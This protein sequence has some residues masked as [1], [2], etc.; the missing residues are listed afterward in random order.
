MNFRQSNFSKN[1][2]PIA[3][4]VILFMALGNIGKIVSVITSVVGLLTP[5]ILGG[6][7]AF[8][9]NMPLIFFEKQVAKYT[10]KSFRTLG[11]IF[12]LLVVAS[13]I[14]IV[15]LLIAP[16]ITASFVSIA[17]SVPEFFTELQDMITKIAVSTPFLKE[18]LSGISIDWQK[19]D[20][21]AVWNT[22]QTFFSGTSDII[23]STVSVA[24]SV[25]SGI[26][27][28]F[29]ALFFSIYVLAQKENLCRQAKKL[30]YAVIPV[31]Y[32]DK[33]VYICSL[34]SKTFKNFITGQ[35]TEAVI[36]G[37]MFFI[38]MSILGL[39]YALLI[40]VLIGVTS[41]VPIFGATVG[42]IVGTFFILIENP[43]QAVYFLIVFLIVQQ[44]EGNVIYPRVV[45]GSVGLPSI[46]VLVAVT[47]GGTSMGLLGMIIFIPLFSIIY[48]LL[49]SFAN[50]RLKKNKIP[51]HK[52]DNT[53]EIE[54]V[55]ELDK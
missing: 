23:G 45:G 37:T 9:L 14:V 33:V 13:V 39:P 17:Q 29:L 38:V 2:I 34:T 4:G 47:V 48:T 28:L 22:V 21:N 12:S 55:E 44:I 11:I 10:K 30:L 43:M 41:L 24:S 16:Q 27:N 42:C 25:V 7:I 5:F 3:F 8:I 51:V 19:I 32:S 31:K 20:W 46:W 36:L 49:R 53:A 40:S 15:S 54:E 35:C 6:A 18:T 52:W 26:V 1:L 50:E